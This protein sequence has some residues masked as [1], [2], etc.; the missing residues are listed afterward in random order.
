MTYKKN[1]KSSGDNSSSETSVLTAPRYPNPKILLLDMKD[2]TASVLK[3]EGYNVCTG[4]F[5]TPYKV[6]KKDK[7]VP[8]IPNHSM[9][10]NYTEQE[11]VVVDLIPNTPFDSPLGEKPVSGGEDDFWASC[12]TGII[13]PRFRTMILSSDKLDRILSHGGIFVIFSDSRIEREIIFGHRDY[14]NH[15]T[16]NKRNIDN[17]CFLRT[18]GADY[19]EIEPD[20]GGEIS[21][22]GPL[23]EILSEHL[24]GARFS[25]TLRPTY[26][27]AKRWHTHAKN[28]YNEPVASLIRGENGGFIFIFP[29]LSN[30]GSL[31]VKLLKDFFPY[32]SPKLFPHLEGA[33]WVERPEYEIP[34]ILKL[35]TEIGEIEEKSK[36]QVEKLK[37]SIDEIRVSEDYIHDLI[38]STDSQL[39]TAV[40]RTLENLGFKKV[41]DVDQ[42]MK[43]KAETGPKREDLQ[44]RDY[45]TIL[46][47]EVKGINGL[48]KENDSL[49]VFKYIAPRMKEEGT[50]DI[51]GISIINHQ[52]IL[53]A[54]ERNKKPFQDDIIVN[55][56]EQNFGIMTTW[57][58]FRLIRSFKKNKWNHDQVKDLFYK[59]GRIEPVPK[60]YKYIGKI[61]HY[62]EEQGALSVRLET[63]EI[64]L[65]DRIAFE[66]PVE[67]EE[68]VVESLQL[69]KQPIEVAQVG[70]E[71]G[72]KTHLTKNQAR[73]GV[74]VF[75]VVE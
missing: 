68:Q 70:T 28:K 31:L 21:C 22:E 71:V 19:I 74:C 23:N 14:V 49:Q 27:T 11:I 48:P 25:C 72:I 50:T 36:N 43:E 9:P 59:D 44:I 51:K 39:V 57:D 60:H 62:W 15:L 20:N 12:C 65:H 55:A 38:R 69:D 45:Q 13:D 63:S 7:Y 66:L 17:W 73:K 52:R 4:S 33:R 54:L 42:R 34:E 1:R 58:L 6:E 37:L 8:V 18:L 24:D 26:K 3:K 35:Q 47:A 61:E 67:F 41:I 30:K 29:Q 10:V 16:G 53:P 46:L 56:Q 2:E 64:K 32:I 75:R 5:G 40:K